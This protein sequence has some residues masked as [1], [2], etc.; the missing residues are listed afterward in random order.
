[1]SKRSSPADRSADL[2]IRHG[3]P[4]AYDKKGC[5]CSVCGDAYRKWRRPKAAAYR[6]GHKDTRREYDLSHRT[7]INQKRRLRN[8]KSLEYAFNHNKQWTGPE[9]EIAERPDM[10]DIQ[11]GAM[12]GRSQMAVAMIRHRIRN[13]P[14][15]RQ[16]N[17]AKEPVRV[18]DWV[19]GKP[20]RI[21]DPAT[22]SKSPKEGETPNV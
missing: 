14:K 9:M 1:M 21:P 10:T 3:T 4:Y 6:A 16:I 11:V 15:Y 12:L 2:S 22:Q 5:R 18:Y 13:E 7:R 20:K 17:G 19:D 8:D